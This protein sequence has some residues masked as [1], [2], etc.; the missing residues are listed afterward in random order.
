MDERF[1]PLLE[2]IE[3]SI[4]SFLPRAPTAAWADLSF[5]SDCPAEGGN[6]LITP[7]RA[8]VD[9]GGKRWRPLLSVLC[10]R[11]A[12]H[13]AAEELALKLCPLVEAVHT[14]S[15]IHDDIED[16]STVRRGAP[17][18]YVT[19]GLDTAVNAASWLYFQAATCIQSASCSA[20]TKNR[21][22]DA[23]LTETRRMH[24]GQ[25]LDIAWHSAG[26]RTPS[27]SEYLFMTGCKT[28]SLAALAAAVGT[29]CAAQDD[30][31]VRR[32]E[33]IARNIGAGFQI[34]DDVINLTTGNPGKR[35]GDDI[36]EGKKSLIVIDFMESAK[37]NP[38]VTNEFLACLKDASRDG[39]ESA[40]VEKAIELLEASHSIDR[41]AKKG[42]DLIQ[43]GA[44]NFVSLFGEDN[45]D[46]LLIKE[47]FISMIPKTVR[48]M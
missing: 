30:T 14:A 45:K 48:S 8:L 9:L 22:Y 1:S 35:R 4:D 29:L 43:S 21:L 18:A 39:I 44:D 27:E 16:R 7:T 20:D 41:A 12:S 36:V 40:S 47:L 38:A 42:L 25:A 23:Y 26:G 2:K 6:R 11:A 34:I 28:G 15:L 32:A 33:D 19:Y 17:A 13:G 10:A 24:L 31:Q 46:A 5:A 3:Q 37:D